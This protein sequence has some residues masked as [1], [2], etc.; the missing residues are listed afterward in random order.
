ML[1]RPGPLLALQTAKFDGGDAVDRVRR[2][3]IRTTDDNVVR[4][5]QQ[6]AMIRRWAPWKEYT[7]E[8]S[9][10]S[11]FFSAQ[12]HLCSYLIH[13]SAYAHE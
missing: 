9:D 6:E 8:E 2:A 5:T 4:P 11:P 7:L 1:L 3:Y 10:H 12:A 13:A